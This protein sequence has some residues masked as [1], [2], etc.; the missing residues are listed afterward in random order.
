MNNHHAHTPLFYEQILTILN[1]YQVKSLIDAT[2]AEGGHGLS[3]AKLKFSVLGIEWDKDM[4]TLGLSNI[5]KSG[6]KNVQLALGNYKD[7]SKIASNW[8]FTP[9]GAV[10]FDLGLSMYQ[11]NNSSKG[12]SSNRQADLDLRIGSDLKLTA[13]EFLNTAGK[14]EIVDVITRYVEDKHSQDLANHIFKYRLVQKINKISDLRTIISRVVVTD[15]EVTKLLRQLLQA[16]R[17]VV[18]DEL[19]N[20]RQGFLGAIK[21]VRKNGLIIFLTYHSLEDRYVKLL[22]QELEAEVKP[23]GKVIKNKD[24]QFAKSGQ[25]RIYEKIIN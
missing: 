14:D 22:G 25:L 23:V 11:L 8:E 6:L 15:K 17:I 1:Q 2:F 21:V 18:N 16:L 10:I 12:F 9:A 19:E 13:S 7:I 24:Y 5:E 20:I 4:Y 3:Y